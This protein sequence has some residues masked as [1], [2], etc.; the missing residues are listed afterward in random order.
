MQFMSTSSQDAIFSSSNRIWV[1][2]HLYFQVS[3]EANSQKGEGAIGAVTAAARKSDGKGS[4]QGVYGSRWLSVCE[5]SRAR[6]NNLFMGNS[7]GKFVGCSTCLKI[8]DN[9][10]PLKER[11]KL[12]FN[13]ASHSLCRSQTLELSDP[14]HD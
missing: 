12:F 13:N 6:L 3:D 9:T 5:T 7:K 4:I 2:P 11:L 14:P 10:A 1:F 8:Y